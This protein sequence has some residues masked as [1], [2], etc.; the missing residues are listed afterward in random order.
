MAR[1]VL[2]S[3]VS[4]KLNRKAKAEDLYISPLFR[5][6]LRYA[7]SLS[8]DKIFILS[9]KYGLLELDKEVEPYEKTLNNMASDEKKNWAKLVLNQIQTHC[10]LKKDTFIL[11]AGANY[12]RF[13]I[14]HMQN[15]S[16]PMSGL[17]I[18]KQLKW[19]TENTKNE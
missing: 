18:G 12:R 7:R 11:L 2:I 8:P 14:P 13:L 4:K 17:G 19:L 9:A 3:C 6:N 16:I 15:H 1:V 10:D 5:K